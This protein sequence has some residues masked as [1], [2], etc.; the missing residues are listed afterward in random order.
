MYTNHAVFEVLRSLSGYPQSRL[1]ENVNDDNLFSTE[2]NWADFDSRFRANL[3]RK[4]E[5]FPGGNPTENAR[6]SF[7]EV[8][9]RTSVFNERLP[10]APDHVKR[11]I[12]MIGYLLRKVTFGF[13]PEMIVPRLTFGATP[14]TKKGCDE[15]EVFNNRSLYSPILLSYHKQHSIK[16]AFE[17]ADATRIISSSAKI[18][19]VPKKWNMDRTITKSSHHLRSYQNGIGDWLTSRLKKVLNIDLSTAQFIHRDIAKYSSITGEFATIDLSSASDTIGKYWLSLL[20]Q[21]LYEY[22]MATREEVGQFDDGTEHVFQTAAGNGCGWTFPFETLLFWCICASVY[23]IDFKESTRIK[24]IRN[25]IFVYGDDIIVLNEYAPRV[26]D[27]LQMLG[28]KPNREKTFILGP[29]RESC[30]GDYYNGTLVRPYYAKKRPE[31]TSEWYSFLNG[32]YRSCYLD[33]GNAWR[34]NF[35][36]AL[37]S[38]LIELIPVEHRNYG[39]VHLGDV[40]LHTPDEGD[41]LLRRRGRMVRGYV[42]VNASEKETFYAKARRLHCEALH[43]SIACTMSGMRGTSGRTSF[44][45]GTPIGSDDESLKKRSVI[46]RDRN[47]IKYVTKN[48]FLTNPSFMEGDVNSLF[49]YLED[50]KTHLPLLD[51]DHVAQKRADDV[52]SRHEKIVGNGGFLDVLRALLQR[53]TEEEA[54]ERFRLESL[55]REVDGLWS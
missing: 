11:Y 24:D 21:P 8:E 26:L 42:P 45:S 55:N 50:N 2:D 33:N 12:R 46:P 17:L 54:L 38:R 49:A 18:D 5:D 13:K 27:V 14:N 23:I 22:I 4:V 41:W 3:F 30:G 31:S 43:R 1:W 16:D 7:I 20:P 15:L 40:V 36:L 44:G 47:K 51:R 37:W 48:L 35:Y 39:P 32:I 29:A 6:Q 9:R 28:F 53:R 25:N 52:Y 34:H 10:Y 19:F